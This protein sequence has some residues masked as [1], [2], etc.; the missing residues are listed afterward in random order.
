MIDKEKN[1]EKLIA[2]GKFKEAIEICQ[3]IAD[4]YWFDAE[5]CHRVGDFGESS[6][7]ERNAEYWSAKIQELKQ[8]ER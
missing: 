4:Y 2:Q 7:A 1:A 3:E 8:R 5:S 6:K